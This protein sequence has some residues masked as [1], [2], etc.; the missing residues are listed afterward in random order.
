MKKSS[1]PTRFIVAFSG[2]AFVISLTLFFSG[3]NSG[4]IPQ[5]PSAPKFYFGNFHAHTSYSDGSG[6]PKEAYRYA[7]ETGELDFL[8]ITEH[9]HAKAGPTEGERKDDLLIA[10]DPS[11]YPKLISDANA[12]NE[13]NAFVAIYGQEF[14]TMSK[15]NHT[16]IFMANKVI[17]TPNGEYEKVFSS[18]WMTGFGV[19]V[20]QLN[21]PWDGKD[22]NKKKMSAKAVGSSKDTNYGFNRFPSAPAFVRALDGRATMIEVINGPGLSNP[23]EDEV[24]F[25][26]VKPAF[27]IAYLNLGLHLAPTGD[28]DNHYRTWGTLSETR[29]VVVAPRL[30]RSEILRAMKERRVYASEDK[31]LKVL[32]TVN[33]K[34]MGSINPRLA[35][36]GIAKIS[37]SI[38]DED[39]PNSA[40]RVSI[41]YDSGPGDAEAT[42]VGVLNVNNN[43]SGIFTHSPT[44][45]KGYY[46]L[47]VTSTADANEGY[48]AW[49]APVWFE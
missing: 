30:T 3:A 4:A 10:T 2:A 23:E 46:F 37:V 31:D 12:A 5:P 11:L 7:R 25:G 43:A 33:G 27:Y 41:F 39:E 49:T 34:L 44:A 16:N 19:Q 42:R 1:F 18:D 45:D 32:F 47:V 14:S 9:N 20:I 38:K 24:L 28:Q 17:S 15:G 13:D 40:Y 22:S 21:H 29:T 35:T 36:G 48:S 26:T 6:T 8:A